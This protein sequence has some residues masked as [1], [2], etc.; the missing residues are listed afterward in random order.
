[1]RYSSQQMFISVFS[2]LN[3]VSMLQDRLLKI[4][5]I[6][7]TYNVSTVKLLNSHNSRAWN[8]YFYIHLY[9]C[10]ILSMCY[11]QRTNIS[12]HRKINTSYSMYHLH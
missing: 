7:P 12:M 5:A 2:D 1:M 9:Q 11:Y 8:S 4:G 6:L 10:I 3:T